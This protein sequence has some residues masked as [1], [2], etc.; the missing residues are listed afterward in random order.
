MIT[1][2]TIW[3]DPLIIDFFLNRELKEGSR[4]VYNPKNN[5]L[6][7]IRR[8]NPT[9]LIEEAERESDEG[10]KPRNRKVKKYLLEFREHLKSER[11]IQL[12]IS[13]ML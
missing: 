6:L 8:I 7:Q 13:K 3:E 9:E 11:V 12:I 2:E 10:I 5:T 4:K 1:E